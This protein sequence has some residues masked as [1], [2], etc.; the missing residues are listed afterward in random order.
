MSVMK[1]EYRLFALSILGLIMFS[2]LANIVSAADNAAVQGFLDNV[3]AALNPIAKFIVG[4]TVT[5][6]A[7]VLKVLLLILLFAIIHMVARRVPGLSQ[8]EYVIFIIAI[9]LSIIAVRFLAS[10]AL[11]RFATHPTGVLGV[12]LV[13]LFPFVLFFFFIEG[14]ES[15]IIRRVGWITFVILYIILTT[16]A[17]PSLAINESAQWWNNFG[18]VYIIIAILSL[19][20]FVFDKTI[21]AYFLMTAIEQKGAELQ[22]LNVAQLQQQIQQWRGII[23]S[24]TSTQQQIETARNQIR[25]LEKRL[26]MLLKS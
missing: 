1:K 16:Y 3:A 22:T 24:P 13:T 20:S 11:V 14:Y 9:V 21:H 25:D 7:L 10:E 19:L 5:G 26:K 23:V 15:G 17:W 2:F 6:E 8:Y 4:D 18:W 12:A